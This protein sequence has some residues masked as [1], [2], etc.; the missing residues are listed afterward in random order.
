MAVD[1][2]D[3]VQL[4]TTRQQL[5]QFLLQPQRVQP[6]RRDAADDHR[7]GAAAQRRLH[8]AAAAARRRGWTAIRSAPHRCPRRSAPAACGPDAPGSSAPRS[9]RR[10]RDPRRP[11]GRWRTG[12]PVRPRRGRSG[13]R[14]AA[15]S[16]CR[17]PAS[18]RCRSSRRCCQSGSDLI[19]AICV[20]WVPIWSAVARAPTASTSAERT[21]S[22]WLTIH[23]SARAPPIEPPT[24]AATSVMPS[25]A[26][27]ATSA[28]TW[29]RTDTSGNLEPQG[30]PSRRR[31]TRARSTRGS[32]PARWWRPHTSGRCRSARRVRPRRPTSLASGGL[33]RPGR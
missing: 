19:A 29:S 14:T 26:S 13:A 9:G 11:G 5:G 16:P 32:R 4:G 15:R 7:D 18:G 17:R 20:L 25:A 2:V 33:D 8:A 24:T 30:F 28:S 12:C 23:S 10:S 22:G 31:R 1:R 3:H 21:V 6:V 27:A